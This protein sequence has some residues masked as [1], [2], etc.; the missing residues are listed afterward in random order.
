MMFRQEKAGIEKYDL[1]FGGMD[2][3]KTSKVNILSIIYGLAILL[4]TAVVMT[5]VLFFGFV[6]LFQAAHV[7]FSIA[8]ATIAVLGYV[9]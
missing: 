9:V 3:V 8:A 7:V 4:S 5:I 2:E 1:V 6:V